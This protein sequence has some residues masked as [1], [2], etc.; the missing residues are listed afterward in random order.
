M[1]MVRFEFLGTGNAFL[2]QGRYHSLLLI[3]SEILID[4]PPTVLASLRRRELSPSDIKTIMITHWHGDHV[5]GFPFLI[6]EQKYISDRDSNVILNVHCPSNGEE[7]LNTL[8][9]IAY[10]ESL[11]DRMKTNVQI[12]E[13]S[14]GEV[15]GVKGW[16]FERFKVLH[17]EVV[18][19]HGYVLT[20]K[21]GFKIM[22][23]GDSGP[24]EAIES[25]VGDC[26][27]VVIELGVPDNVV[28]PT[29]FRPKTLSELANKFPQ[30]I[31]LVTHHYAD[32]INSG[33]KPYLSNDLPNLPNNV[34]QV[35]DE[36]KFEWDAGTFRK[37]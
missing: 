27:V 10:P 7:K 25:R 17:D 30:T 8:C 12:S 32:D 33:K 22:H 37:L 35:C 36:Q 9:E 34:T 26:D 5:F 16:N 4:V 31:F 14:S 15:L 24:C 1:T 23:T 6:L 28:V 19:P 3:E 20:H 13:H 18:D 11:T 21:S 2:P 29:H